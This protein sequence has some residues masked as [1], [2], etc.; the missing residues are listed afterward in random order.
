MMKL[1]HLIIKLLI[2]LLHLWL[3]YIK[4]LLKFNKQ[5][6]ILS[7]V[8][9]FLFFSQLIAHYVFFPFAIILLSVCCAIFL[10]RMNLYC[11]SSRQCICLYVYSYTYRTDF[12]SSIRYNDQYLCMFVCVNISLCQLNSLITY[13]LF[14]LP[15]I[16]LCNDFL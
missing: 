14:F 7:R 1:H 12:I 10:R 16:T 8:Y 9:L 11:F 4:N 13:V 15:I 2:H 6:S 5:Y 3:M